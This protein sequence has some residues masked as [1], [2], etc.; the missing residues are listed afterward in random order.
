MNT[1]SVQCNASPSLFSFVFERFE[2]RYRLFDVFSTVCEFFPC[3]PRL[4]K[5]LNFFLF[6]PANGE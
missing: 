3:T 2:A 5:F 1:E 4:V 6:L